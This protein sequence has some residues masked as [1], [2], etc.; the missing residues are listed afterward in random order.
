MKRALW[1]MGICFSIT[2]AIV[3]G[4][5][6]SADALAVII[7]IVLG[8]AST[9]PTTLVTIYLLTRQRANQQTPPAPYQPPVVVI[10][11]SDRPGPPTMSLP[12]VPA[13]PQGRQWTVIGDADTDGEF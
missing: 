12:A 3:F 8:V 7:G 4:L 11:G 9:V 13:S 10:N 1:V 6:V 2:L 5:R